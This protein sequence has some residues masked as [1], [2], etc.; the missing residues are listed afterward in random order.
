MAKGASHGENHLLGKNSLRRNER[1][2]RTLSL[3]R[4]IVR[5]L[6]TD[7]QQ[8]AHTLQRIVDSALRA[9]I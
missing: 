6:K 8:A 7:V 1:N 4:K 3:R 9:N 2:P 5:N